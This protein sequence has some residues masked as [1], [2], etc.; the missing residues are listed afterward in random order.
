MSPHPLTTITAANEKLSSFLRHASQHAPLDAIQGDAMSAI[1][2]ELP[3]VA[4]VVE[5]AAPAVR[6]LTLSHNLNPEGRSQIDLYSRNLQA[7]KTLL[8]SLLASAQEKR[9]RLTE[10]TDKIHEA[11][12]WLNTLGL[13]KTD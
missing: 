9:K 5:E 12:S 7:L 3:A 1:E 6:T 11:Q 4:S 13:T 2:A 10:N 8:L